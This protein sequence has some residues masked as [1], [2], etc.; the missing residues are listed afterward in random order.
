MKPRD[1]AVQLYSLREEA[2]TDFIKVLERVA[3]IGYIAVEPAGFYNLT[4][5]E[6][7]NIIDDLGLKMYS[8][9]TPWVK[10]EDVSA[11]VEMAGIL[12][13]DKVVCGYG[14][15]D[16]KDFDAI[17]RTADK[18]NVLN[19]KITAAGLTLFQ[20]N[21]AFEFE[22][23]DGRLKYE[24]YAELCPA[25]KFQMDAFWSSNFGA[26]DP[27][28]MMK[29]F[30]DRIILVHLKDGLFVQPD[31]NTKMVNGFLDRKLELKALG[32]GAMNLPEIFAA[33]PERVN[34]VI[35]ELDYC[36]T[37]MFEAIE[38]SYKYLTSNGLA[39]GNK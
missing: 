25:V 36:N 33:I 29:K 18:T 14:P 12:G 10:N 31:D 16:F 21:H 37:D 32:T 19:E 20:H 15:D 7:K 4:P 30:A 39:A 1:I 38:Q 28:E 5:Q 9:H 27:A 8:S 3:G 23:I 22:R 13:L 26:E 6:F 24:I 34:N 17:K 35:V 2:K 11:E